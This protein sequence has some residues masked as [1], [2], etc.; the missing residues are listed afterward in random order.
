MPSEQKCGPY[1]RTRPGPI[2]G[3]TDLSLIFVKSLSAAA[4]P[5]ARV[6]FTKRRPLVS[7]K[8]VDLGMSAS[9][10]GRQKTTDNKNAAQPCAPA[11]K[12]NVHG[13][14]RTDQGTIS[15]PRSEQVYKVPPRS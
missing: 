4:C 9:W 13:V 12:L 3:L 10:P 11:E 7:P 6:L 15:Y 14:S 5:E 8:G 2:L 1:C